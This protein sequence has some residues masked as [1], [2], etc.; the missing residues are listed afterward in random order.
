M[1][2][3]KDEQDRLRDLDV[4]KT[5]PS[6]PRLIPSLTVEKG[7]YSLSH[8][9]NSMMSRCRKASSAQIDIKIFG[10]ISMCFYKSTLGLRENNFSERHAVVVKSKIVSVECKN[11]GT[12]QPCPFS[13]RS[14]SIII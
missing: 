3:E 8:S 2:S 9:H 5:G 4:L 1:K 11:A 6:W 13:N 14:S 10:L 7:F 12:R